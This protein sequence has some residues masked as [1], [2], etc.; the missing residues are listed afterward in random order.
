VSTDQASGGGPFAPLGTTPLTLA[1]YAGPVK[2]GEVTIAFRR[3]ID[4]TQALRT[5]T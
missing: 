4:T 5:G 3:H 2:N 1:T